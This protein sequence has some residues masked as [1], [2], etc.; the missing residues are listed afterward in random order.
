MPEFVLGKFSTMEIRA[1]FGPVYLIN[2]LAV[3]VG[4]TGSS[5]P[6]RSITTRSCRRSPPASSGCCP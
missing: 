4:L 5:S 2:F 6:V 1:D 3:G